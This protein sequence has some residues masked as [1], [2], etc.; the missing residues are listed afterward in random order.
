[1]SLKSQIEAYLGADGVI[2]Q[3]VDGYQMRQAQMDMAETIADII[4]SEGCLLAEAGTG[5]GK[6]FSYLVPALLSGQKV[7]VSTATKT[8]QD[9]LLR[10]DIPLLMDLCRVAGTVKVLKGRENYLCPQRLEI[11]E[12]AEQNTQSVWQKLNRIHDWQL[13]TRS[14]DKAE[15]TNLDDNDPLWS[16]VCARLEFCQANDCMGGET[17]CFYPKVKQ[18]ALD[19]QVLI[20]NHHLFCA[21]LAL[22]EQGF[23]E[24][25]PEADI[26]IFDEAHQLPDIAAQFLG[27]SISRY[28]LDELV[29]DL[30]LAYQKEAPEVVELADQTKALEQKITQFHESLGKWEKRWT[31]QVFEDAK[32]PVKMLEQLRNQLGV[33]IDTLKPLTD[34][35][36]LLSALSKRSQAFE[37]QLQSW[38]T[39]SS[40]NQVRW[41]ESS[42]ARFKLNLTPLSVAAPFSRQREALG[43]AWIFTSATLSVNH[44]F[45]YFAHRLG[46]DD[47]ET[48]QWES[49]FDYARQAVIYHP[50]GLPDPKDPDYIKICL[51][52]A[53][54]LLQESR[55][56]AFLLFTSHRALQEARTILAEHWDGTLLV[57]GDGPKNTLLQRFKDND[58][59]LLLGTSS[60]WEGVDVKGEALKLVLIDRI[61]FIPPDDPVVQAREAALK[62]KGLSAFF[63]FQIPEATIALKQ[64]IGR[65]IRD[66]SDYGV[67]MLCDPRLTQ[68]SYGAIITNSFPNFNW[69]FS[70]EEA[71][72]KLRE[73]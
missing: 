14:G 26:Y 32:A 53:W 48:R 73:T 3:A 8:L 43:G 68:K 60:F 23:G 35:G 72:Q 69:V 52:A 16:K 55:G 62:Q 9:Q 50:L 20:V 7:I 18:Q 15:L 22:R 70:V 45:D 4:E 13:K 54:P 6:T 1:M 12:T 42:Q 56:C 21:D 61:P 49:P 71:K 41:A 28:Q 47:A 57:Q 44:R 30:K 34:K 65:L 25:L 19:A 5:T 2:A 38:L 67:L 46:L 63:H 31:W 33:L 40:D 59:A 58:R 29:R 27:F 37:K 51:R 64:G 24:V 36:K 11:A 17:D 10:K 39:A 66:T